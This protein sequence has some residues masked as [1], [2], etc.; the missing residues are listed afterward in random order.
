M[1]LS[2]PSPGNHKCY[3]KNYCCT[4][5]YPD[6]PLV[7]N[8][9]RYKKLSYGKCQRKIKLPELSIESI[10]YKMPVLDILPRSN[11][12]LKYNIST[13]SRNEIG[14][15]NEKNED[16]TPAIKEKILSM[17][18]DLTNSK[19]QIIFS[20]K[21]DNN[22]SKDFSSF[23]NAGEKEISSDNSIPNLIN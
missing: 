7:N 22:Y 4:S 20:K 11:K 10:K 21:R 18:L 14:L 17:S 15:A 8:N 19:R 9:I 12:E 16:I 3:S 5:K 23:F 1:D 2:F 13:C 6:H